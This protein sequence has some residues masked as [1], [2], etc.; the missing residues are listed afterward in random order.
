M[1]LVSYSYSQHKLPVWFRQELPNQA[2]LK[3]LCLLKEAKVHTVCQAAGCPNL[4]FCF[5]NK[6]LTFLILG[7]ACSRNC[8]FCRVDKAGGIEPLGLDWDEPQRIADMVRGLGLNYVVIT[9][10][11]RDDLADGGAS[12]FTKTIEL[13]KAIDKNIKIEVLIPD[14]MGRLSSLECVVN[15]GPEVIAHNIETAKRLY[16]QVRPLADYFLSLEVLNKIKKLSPRLM[17]KSSLMLG[18]GETE[19]EVIEAMRDLRD[20]QCDAL[21]LGQYLAPSSAHYPVKE[22][23]TLEQFQDYKELGLQ[24]GFKSVF[25]GPLVRSSYR[26]EETYLCM[27]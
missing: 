22:F 5:K 24:L 3:K 8:K 10:V 15:A 20:C 23:I 19:K 25:S 4:S 16:P 21:T 2:V 14:F 27:S 13:I 26:A 11:T 18:L 1:P 9:S 7:D 6:S 17:T 12:V